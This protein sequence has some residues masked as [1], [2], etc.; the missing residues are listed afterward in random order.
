VRG[1]RPWFIHLSYW[2]PHPPYV[3]PAPYHARY[4]PAEVPAPLRAAS[5]EAE[6]A[7]H[8]WLAH[9]LAHPQG[10]APVWGMAPEEIPGLSD[11]DLRQ[12]RAA[13]YGLASEVDHQIG[14]L[15]DHLKASGAY[16]ETLIVFTSDHGDL[17]GDHWQFSK[18]SYF[19]Q[20]FH[21]PLIVRD[22]RAAAAPGRG[23]KVA[24]FSEN[25]DV[26]PTILEALGLEVPRQ[27][28]GLSLAPFLAGESPADWRAEAHWEYDFRDLIHR[29]PERAL[30]LDSDQCLMN[31]IRGER[32]KYVHFTAL[33]PVFFDLQEDPGET[34]NLAGDPAYAPLVLDHAQRL[35]SWRMEHEERG[36]T[37]CLLTSEGLFRSSK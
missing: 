17:L 28:D 31:V 18:Y 36:L 21:V 16:E 33:P 1:E 20:A 6:G 24:A 7:Q 37:D 11:R 27:C 14:R 19:D 13:Y 26:M 3:A 9:R 8:P 10:G 29:V 22:P 30:G 4:D 12:M 2:A 23:R 35:L 15:I 32:Y 5:P 34:R 25:V